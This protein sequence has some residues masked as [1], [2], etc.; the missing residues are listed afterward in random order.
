MADEVN[1]P[2]ESPERMAVR[3]EVNQIMTNPQNQYYEA[4]KRNDPGVGKY[5]NSLYAKLPGAGEKIP[6]SDDLIVSSPSVED[7]TDPFTDLREKWGQQYEEKRAASIQVG[8]ELFSG[9]E[10]AAIRLG[11]LMG[12][13][14]VI[15]LFPQLRHDFELRSALEVIVDRLNK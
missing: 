1:T 3:A 6:I 15:D 2:T 12:V 14:E 13:P 11:D 8:R 7:A 9:K 10:Q 4:F 5:I